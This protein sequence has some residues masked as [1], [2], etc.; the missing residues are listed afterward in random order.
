MA[1]RRTQRGWGSDGVA[2]RFASRVAPTRLRGGSCRTRSYGVRRHPSRS[3]L[4]RA[5]STR[6]GPK[7][8]CQQGAPPPKR[9]AEKHAGVT[10]ET[11]A[12][13]RLGPRRLSANALVIA[14]GGPAGV[15]AAFIGTSVPSSACTKRTGAPTSGAAKRFLSIPAIT[16]LCASG[17]ALSA[18]WRDPGTLEARGDRSGPRAVAGA[19]ALGRHDAPR[20]H[21]RSPAP[22]HHGREAPGSPP[23]GTAASVPKAQCPSTP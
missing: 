7:R 13:R 10:E 22:T 5:T 11:L 17:I 9:Q 16:T 18:T 15:L 19:L 14:R 20:A 8:L 1:P 12:D 6:R 4:V 23:T 3:A 2:S 21:A